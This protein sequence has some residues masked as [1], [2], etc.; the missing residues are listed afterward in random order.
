MNPPADSFLIS[1][2]P[3]YPTWRY[4]CQHGYLTEAPI[5]RILLLTDTSSQVDL[6]GSLAVAS[7][8]LFA[9]G[10][11]TDLNGECARIATFLAQDETLHRHTQKAYANSRTPVTYLSS[12]GKIG[13]KIMAVGLINNDCYSKQ[14]KSY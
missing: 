5:Y 11:S 8:G 4:Y 2:P 7:R 3:E 10:V 14:N 12:G 1:E 6:G 13:D 9:T